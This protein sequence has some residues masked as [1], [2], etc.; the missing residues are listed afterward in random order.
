[1]T[2]RVGSIG[3][4]QIDGWIL[5]AGACCDPG[6]ERLFFTR[7][8]VLLARPKSH[9]HRPGDRYSA[10]SAPVKPAAALDQPEDGAAWVA[11]ALRPANEAG[12]F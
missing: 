8:T 2:A 6:H 1:M 5:L 12:R 3:L 7:P 4:Q 10:W 11:N 9:G